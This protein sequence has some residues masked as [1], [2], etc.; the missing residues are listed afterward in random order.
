MRL[1]LAFDM[2]EATGP[3]ARKPNTDM[4]GFS[5]VYNSLVAMPRKFDCHY[6]ARDA[7]WL[8]GKMGN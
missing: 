1:I 5:D 8:E 2:A 4:L 6:T 7:K 3:G